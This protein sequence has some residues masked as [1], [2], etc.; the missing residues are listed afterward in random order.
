[1]YSPNMQVAREPLEKTLRCSPK[2]DICKSYRCVHMASTY[3]K[4]VNEL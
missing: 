1:M 2:G 4:E 3:Q